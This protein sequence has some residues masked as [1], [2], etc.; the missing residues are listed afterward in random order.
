MTAAT[1][2]KVAM[3]FVPDFKLVQNFSA[4]GVRPVKTGLNQH[5]FADEFIPVL[6]V[7]QLVSHN[8]CQRFVVILSGGKMNDRADPAPQF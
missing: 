8:V 7:Q 5:E 4:D 6:I 2:F 1:S 3:I